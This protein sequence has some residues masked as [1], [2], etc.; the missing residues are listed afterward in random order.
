LPPWHR[1]VRELV[2][3]ADD[4]GVDGVNVDVEQLDELDRSAYGD[5]LR[6]LRTELRAA[7]PRATLSVATEA[8]PRGTG[9]AATA[10]Q[11]GVDRVF[12]MGYDYHSSRSQPG[13]SSPVD[14]SDGLYDLRWSVEQ[15][16]GAGVP[17]DQILLGLPL[18]GMSWRT[19]GPDRFAPVLGK[20]VSWIP[21]LH[22]DVL[23]D[24]AFQ[25]ARD[26]LEIAEFFIRPDGDAWRVTYYD[27]PATLRSKLAFAR[28]Q[29]LAGG[30]FWALGYDRG[31][32]G[33][34]DLMHDFRRGKVQR[35]EAPS[36]PAA[37]MAAET[38]ND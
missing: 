29:G 31:L 10:M 16:V 6:A 23:L 22:R 38:P 28:D 15:Y 27:S 25:P 14:R 37:T 18:Y 4:L 33:Y 1:A 3:L 8:G 34:V 24:P 20:G 30:G 7:A 12:L 21:S 5:F 36:A 9:N 17:R 2:A 35:E 26:P 13:A 19:A 11:A 32:P